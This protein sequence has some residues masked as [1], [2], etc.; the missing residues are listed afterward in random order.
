MSLPKAN[1]GSGGR[2]GTFWSKTIS[3]GLGLASA[4]R[5][6]FRRG[7]SLTPLYCV[8]HE[9][10]HVCVGGGGTHTLIKSAK[11]KGFGS[12]HF[13]ITFLLGFAWDC[14]SGSHCSSAGDNQ[15]KT[16]ISHFEKAGGSAYL[17]WSELRAGQ[18]TG[19]K[20]KF[21]EEGQIM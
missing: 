16:F 5:S 15:V 3:L 2:K 8:V 7:L 17:P 13:L 9:H 20:G 1:I 4:G 19:Q 6:F 18:V 11:C 21:W 14:H 10:M 12:I